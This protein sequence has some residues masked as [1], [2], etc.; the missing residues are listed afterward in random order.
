[1]ND[2]YRYD[3][4]VKQYRRAPLGQRVSDEERELPVQTGGGFY[5]SVQTRSSKQKSRNRRNGS[6]SSGRSGGSLRRAPAPVHVERNLHN[7]H[8]GKFLFW[9]VFL[10]VVIAW[11]VWLGM[12]LLVPEA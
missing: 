8:L 4:E 11:A 5:G 6:S 12:K 7:F 2:L 3:P 9:L 10:A 1:M